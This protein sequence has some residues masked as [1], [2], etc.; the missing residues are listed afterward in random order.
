VPRSAQRRRAADVLGRLGLGARLSHTPQQLS[1]GEQQRVA[2]ARALTNDPT[3][4][5]ADEPCASLDARTA[6]AVLDE[7]LG[8]CRDGRKTLVVVSHEA[9]ALS[10]ADRVVD[11]AD[12]NRVA[13]A[14]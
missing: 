10:A 4:I 6:R 11:I 3:L 2:I 13:A 12:L 1:R 8:V 9:A 7:F 5:L 14:T